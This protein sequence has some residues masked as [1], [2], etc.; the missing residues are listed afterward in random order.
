ML[1][2]SKVLTLLELAPG[3]QKVVRED[4]SGRITAGHLYALSRFPAEEQLRLVRQVQEHGVSA[5][6]LEEFASRRI[7]EL[8]ARKRRRRPADYGRFCTSPTFVGIRFL[9]TFA[10]KIGVG[11][12][13][14]GVR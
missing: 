4:Q 3:V 13:I 9:R 1:Q 7:G 12:R 10:T 6:A 14:E 2:I 8:T 5:T 11:V